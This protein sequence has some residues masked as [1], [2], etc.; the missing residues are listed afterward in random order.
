MYVVHDAEYLK[1]KYGGGEKGEK[2]P[3]D[4]KQIKVPEFYDCEIA[5]LR[6]KASLKHSSINMASRLQHGE[7]ALSLILDGNNPYLVNSILRTMN[8]TQYELLARE[9]GRLQAQL[10][11][12]YKS[13]YSKGFSVNELEDGMLELC[14]DGASTG[15]DE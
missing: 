9:H 5:F 2:L 13:I 12:L 15:C 1:F 4:W 6:A 11:S 7:D 3:Y 10:Q 14:T 8:N